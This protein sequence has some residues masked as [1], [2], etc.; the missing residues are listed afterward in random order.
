VTPFEKK[1]ET[2]RQRALRHAHFRATKQ[3]LPFNLT[4]ADVI[5]PDICPVFG[6]P[7]LLG[8]GRANPRTPTVDA[9]QPELG[10]VKGNVRVISYRASELKSD[11]ADPNELHAVADY[12]DRELTKIET[13]K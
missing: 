11:V 8:L 1:I 7:F 6:R 5:I 9:V 4:L 13:A 3:G 12:M 2:E 10:F